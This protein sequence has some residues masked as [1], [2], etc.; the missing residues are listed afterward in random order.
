[1]KNLAISDMT[2]FAGV[3]PFAK[4]HGLGIEMQGFI[5]PEVLDDPLPTL[6]MHRKALEGFSGTRT[7]H[8][9][10][11]G[12]VPGCKDPLVRE[13][14][15]KRM[16]QALFIANELSCTNMV[17][18]LDVGVKNK[19]RLGTIERDAEFWL[20]A[21]E[22][23]PEDL[24]IHIENIY[25]DLPTP[26]LEFVTKVDHPRIGICFDV[27]HANLFS[28]VPL[29]DWP[30]TLCKKITYVHLHDN[31]GEY[32]E[33]MVLGTGKIDFPAVLSA[34]EEHCP[35]AIWCLECDGAAS[36][37]YLKEKGFY[38]AKSHV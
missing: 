23:A 2:N 1:M 4:E 10:F 3:F 19:F 11:M 15:K 38:K 31:T 26:Q 34:L 9:P 36:L 17:A 21:I 16:A 37:A 28:K 33:H 18:H 35:G 13:A 30:K 14:T 7:L 6:E 25:E 29:T 32:D 24:T 22:T 12:L 20:Q 27:G 8:A 5:F